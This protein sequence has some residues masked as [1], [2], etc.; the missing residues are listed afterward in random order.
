MSAARD[1]LTGIFWL[2]DDGPMEAANLAHSGKERLIEFQIGGNGAVKGPGI[3]RLFPGKI[4]EDFLSVIA[5]NGRLQ[6]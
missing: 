3:L 2:R 6:C 4:A 5:T 1:L